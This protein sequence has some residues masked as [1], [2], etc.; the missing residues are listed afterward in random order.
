[1]SV[2]TARQESRPTFAF[3]AFSAVK[4]AC[5]DIAPFAPSCGKISCYFVVFED[6][7]EDED[8]DE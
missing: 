5:L 8:E 7:N 4:N 1:L 6:E 2:K 3:S